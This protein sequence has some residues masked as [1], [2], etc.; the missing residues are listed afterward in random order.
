[1]QGEGGDGGDA[2]ELPALD[3]A[4]AASSPRRRFA[5]VCFFSLFARL[6]ERDTS[7]R[8][9]TPTPNTSPRASTAAS[10]HPVLNPGSRPTTGARGLSG[11]CASNARTFSPNSIAARVLAPSRRLA[12]ASRS[13][14]GARRRS[15]PSATAASTSRTIFFFSLRW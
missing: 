14:R 2:A 8:Y 10:L 12:R 11:A 6:S 4:V 5:A 1:M 7:G 9:T 3:V 15:T 13:I